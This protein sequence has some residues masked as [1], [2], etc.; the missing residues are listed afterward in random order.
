[1]DRYW[2]TF[3]HEE[4]DYVILIDVQMRTSVLSDSEVK[5]FVDLSSV[6]IPLMR[7]TYNII[8]HNTYTV[9]IVGK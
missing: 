3:T 9:V 6:Q 8:I 2:T 1:M 5:G 7:L 4:A